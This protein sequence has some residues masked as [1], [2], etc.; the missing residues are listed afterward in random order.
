M[1]TTL[2]NDFRKTTIRKNFIGKKFGKSEV[3]DYLGRKGNDTYWLCKC[4]CG[5]EFPSSSRCLQR[6]CD[7]P[8]CWECL[9]RRGKRSH[10]W[11]GIGKVGKLVFTSYKLN[12]IDRGLEF[13][14]TLK[15]LADLFTR[16]R[17]RCALTGR[18]LF[19]GKNSKDWNGRNASLDRI[20]SSK[21]YIK[22]NVQWIDKQLNNIKSNIPNNKFI[23]I[24]FEVVN[25][26]KNNIIHLDKIN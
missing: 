25:F 22:G 10:A 7:T 26:T 11:K 3:I 4:D 18:K 12:A 6:T 8:A 17:E 21:G 20:D 23:D 5:R 13:E 16:Q 2:N 9:I 15:Y 14:L 24:C 19:F 1:H